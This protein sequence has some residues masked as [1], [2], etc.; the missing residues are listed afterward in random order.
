M[1][2]DCPFCCGRIPQHSHSN[3]PGDGGRLDPPSVVQAAGGAVADSSSAVAALPVAEDGAP[4]V[5]GASSLDFRHGLDVTDPGGGPARIAVDE[6][7]FTYGGTGDMTA[8]A[9]GSTVSAGSSGKPS[10]AA[11]RHAMPSAGTP[12]GGYGSAAAGS[13]STLLRSDA[14]LPKPTEADL[15]I[16]DNTTANVSTTAHGFAPK[17]PNDATKYLDGTGAW[18]VPSGGGGGGTAGGT[19]CR[20]TMSGDQTLSNA[21]WTAIQFAGTD[22][23]DPSGL[24]NPASNNTR[25]TVDATGGWLLISSLG[26]NNSSSGDRYTAFAVNGSRIGHRPGFTPT[27]ASETYMPNADVVSLSSGDYV[28][29]HAYQGSGGNLAAKSGTT[30]MVVR[31]W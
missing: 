24:H 20:A 18:T 30:L 5:G 2:C 16:A 27:S 31:L 22:S 15:S 28:E 1:K 17:L 29:L 7:E 8:E 23:F 11:H 12:A 14:V 10:D 4:V 9:I 3:I 25:I 6:S 21:T 19:R 13:A 26:F